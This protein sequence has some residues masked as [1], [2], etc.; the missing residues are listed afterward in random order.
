MSN[1]FS[2]F[3]KYFLLASVIGIFC[4]FQTQQPTPIRNITPIA[5]KKQVKAKDILVDV[6]TPEEFASGHVKKARNSDFSGGQFAEQIQGWDKS[7]TYYLYC[8]SGNR[9][10]KAAQLMSDAGFKHVYNLGAFKD[11]QAN[12]IP[13]S[14]KK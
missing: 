4:F 2:H 1:P 13:V 6:R 10:G 11:L 9:S 5:Y 7:K 8:A 3:I 14:Q 12:G